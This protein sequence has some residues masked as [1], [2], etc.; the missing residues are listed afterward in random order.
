[1]GAGRKGARESHSLV[2]IEYTLYDFISIESIQTCGLPWSVLENV[3]YA[4]WV[5]LEEVF[6]GTWR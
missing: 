4:H 6:R 1:M 2:I 5:L 3:P